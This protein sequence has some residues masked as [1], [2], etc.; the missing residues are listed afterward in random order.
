MSEYLCNADHIAQYQ[1]ETVVVPIYVANQILAIGFRLQWG[2]R[3]NQKL[4]RSCGLNATVLLEARH[5]R[6]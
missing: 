1:M 2:V 3:K 5:P 4:I 6:R